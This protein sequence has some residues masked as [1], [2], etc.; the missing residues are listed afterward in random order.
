MPPVAHHV[1]LGLA[2]AALGGAGL[3]LASLAAPNGADRAVAAVVIAASMAALEALALGLVR[4]GTSTA[5]LASA[6]ALTWVLARSFLPAPKY[7]LGAEFAAAWS[8]AP[9]ARRVALGAVCGVGLAWAVWLLRYPALGIDTV[10]YHL[11][12]VVAWI[13]DGSPGAIEPLFPNVPVGNYPLTN[14]VL[15]AW[16]TGIARSFVFVGL[17]APAMMGLLI[18]AGWGALRALRVPVVAATLALGSLCFLPVLTHYQQ[19]GAN[20]D[21]PALAW[22]VSAAFL[23]LASMRRP[24]LIAPA[25]L[26][27]ALAVGTKTTTLPLALLVLVLA[28]VGARREL[29]RLATPLAL[30]GAAAVA[31]GGYWYLRNL[32]DHGS[33][34][35]PFVETPW[36]DP[37]PKEIG[38]ERGV[39]AS[40]LDHPRFTLERVGSEWLD[41]FCGGFL[42]LAA[43][44]A[45]PFVA[46]DK[47]V[48]AAAVVTAASVL[49]WMNAPF[50]GASVREYEVATASTVRYL[51][52]ALGAAV[53]TLALAAT[54]LSRVARGFAVLLLGAGFVMNVAQTADLGFPSVPRA[55]VPIAGAAIGAGAAGLVMRV[56]ARPPPLPAR[57]RPLLA[58]L[59]CAAVGA[60]A[61]AGAPGFVERHAA[62]ADLYGTDTIR[63]FTDQPAFGDGD[64]PIWAGPV[65]LAPLGG[66][67]LQHEFRWIEHD[68]TCEEVRERARESWV[69]VIMF[70]PDGR[71]LSPSGRCLENQRPAHKGAGFSVYRG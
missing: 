63:W 25:L 13:G 4:L 38:P 45:A 30:A 36:G 50:T 37:L 40:F 26:A 62:T 18:L 14:E 71:L 53:L 43:A 27:A 44:I 12:D 2:I 54:S 42:L 61:A 22:L 29:R 35:W 52:P 65:T 67:R 58:A 31:V 69:I 47:R 16:G 68:A 17:W 57:A 7:P 34:F 10:A 41:L 59:A 9:P 20:T 5:A 33:P 64:D 3:R 23:S 28:L 46:R 8:A 1:V 6:A 60:I 11:T 56:A 24:P 51:I 48:T 15:L 70:P 66:D 49:I 55:W 32:V 19:N 21:I 39:N